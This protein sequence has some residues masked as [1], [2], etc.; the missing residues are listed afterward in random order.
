MK[1]IDLTPFSR[2]IDEYEHIVFIFNDVIATDTNSESY[3]QYNIELFNDFYCAITIDVAGFSKS[4]L[5]VETKNNILK[6]TGQK[7]LKRKSKYLYQG[8]KDRMVFERKFYLADHVKITKASLRYG[9]LIIKL[10]K[11]TYKTIKTHPLNIHSNDKVLPNTTLLAKE[12]K[13]ITAA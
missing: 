10:L 3:P 1:T 8:I 11:Q 6:I 12:V 13:S 5:K 2:G 7:S 9:H 4:E